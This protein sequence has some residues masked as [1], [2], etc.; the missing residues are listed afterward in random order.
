MR[1]W[2]SPFKLTP[3]LASHTRRAR[4]P[5]LSIGAGA[6]HVRKPPHFTLRTPFW[7][8]NHRRA[9]RLFILVLHVDGPEKPS[10]GE[11]P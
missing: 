4:R 3:S 1:S 11:H 2:S 9:F 8:C 7:L 5:F 6:G 10:D